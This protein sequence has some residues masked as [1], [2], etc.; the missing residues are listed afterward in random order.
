MANTV[1]Q[2]FL[3]RIP[4]G[5]LF[6]DCWSCVNRCAM[7]RPRSPALSS[8]GST[9]LCHSF[10]INRLK[11]RAVAS[12]RSIATRTSAYPTRII[13]LI[14]F[15]STPAARLL[16]AWGALSPCQTASYWLLLVSERLRSILWP[17][18]WPRRYLVNLISEIFSINCLI[19]LVSPPGLEPGTY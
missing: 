3:N 5:E 6:L 1:R 14:I 12:L 11:N 17:Q 15:D 13:A 18:T 10:R 16:C 9:F 4:S 19:M 7:D 8:R 2:F